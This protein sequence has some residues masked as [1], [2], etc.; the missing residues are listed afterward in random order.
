MYLMSSLRRITLT[1]VF[2]VFHLS[3]L[4]AGTGLA[5]KYYTNT[6][7]SG[8]AVSRTDTNLNF[9]WPGSPIAGVDSN[10]FSVAWS[11]QIEPEFTELYT[12]YLTADDAARLWVD[13]QCL[14]AR[15]FYQGNGEMRGQIRLKAGHRVNLRVEFIEFTGNA[16]VK[17]E[18]S[19]PSR[20]REVVPMARLYPTH[21]DSQRRLGDA[22]KSGR[23]CRARASRR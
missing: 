21:G 11:G 8:T 2:V 5:G 19:S 16:S 10:N 23:T 15:T 1:V 17:L 14:V 3:A 7:F 20:P 13:D 9:T 6:V 4:A 22:W 18:W 12:F